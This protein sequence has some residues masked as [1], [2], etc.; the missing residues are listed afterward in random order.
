MVSEIHFKKAVRKKKGERRR[1][2]QAWST[3]TVA[4][5]WEN[6]EYDAS[7]GSTL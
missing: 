5:N 1:K 2:G 3:E 4:I 7:K 6:S